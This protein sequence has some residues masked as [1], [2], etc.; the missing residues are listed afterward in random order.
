MTNWEFILVFSEYWNLYIPIL[1]FTGLIY[2][3]ILRRKINNVCDPLFMTALGSLLGASVVVFLYFTE[4]IKLYYFSNYLITQIAFIFPLIL[5]NKKLEVKEKSNFNIKIK[6]EHLLIYIT[7][8]LVTI[9]DSLLQLYIYKVSGIPLFKSSRLETFQGGTGFGIFSRIIGV[10]RFLGIY[11]SMFYIFN[12]KKY[13]LTRKYALIYLSITIIF[14][15]FS[16][17]KSSFLIYINLLFCYS[18]INYG[19]FYKLNA[20]K[21]ILLGI[22]LSS[23]VVLSLYLK[24]GNLKT[25]LMAFIERFVFYV[26]VYWQAYPNDIINEIKTNGNIIT[27]TFVD[28]LGSFRIIPWDMLPEPIGYTLFQIHEKSDLIM[29]A[30]ARHN[31][32]G[33]IYCGY[34]GS[35]I[36]SLILGIILRIG[37]KA[38]YNSK[39]KNQIFKAI[40]VYIYCSIIKVETDVTLAISSIDS[41]IITLPILVFLLIIIYCIIKFTQNGYIYNNSKL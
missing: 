39:H 17:S 13:K 29:G 34:L 21:I 41:L 37:Y 10:T 12:K 26:D 4:N 8:I 2:W 11:F 24:F 27:A 6:D 38:L 25:S 33:F 23:F 36:Y 15:I 5:Y 31:V 40:I 20:N 35:I 32:L 14:G 22:C 30:N 19:T 3:I 16:G 7:F 9:L 18:I 1:I 28:F